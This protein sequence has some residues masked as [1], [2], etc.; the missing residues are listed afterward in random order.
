M[1]PAETKAVWTTN[2][3]EYHVYN[4]RDDLIAV[5]VEDGRIGLGEG[6]YF[7]G[8]W[9][10]DFDVV[11]RKGVCDVKISKI[12]K[13][14]KSP[15][16]LGDPFD[17][18]G[19]YFEGFHYQDITGDEIDMMD[20]SGMESARA[21][22]DGVISIRFVFGEDNLS[23][24]DVETDD[25]GNGGCELVTD[26]GTDVETPADGGLGADIKRVSWRSLR[27]L[28]IHRDAGYCQKCWHKA[29]GYVPGEHIPTGHY[30]VHHLIAREF[31]GSDEHENLLTVCEVCHHAEHFKAPAGADVRPSQKCQCA[32]AF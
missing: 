32:E 8:M 22:G 26:G 14:E 24:A 7:A 21:C 9:V 11:E 23:I 4:D 18:T 5:A 31:G 13:S 12:H 3:V 1:R 16:E 27:E 6:N 10:E 17:H 20:V 25:D 28:V 29:P 30:Q 19:E 2:G 15:E